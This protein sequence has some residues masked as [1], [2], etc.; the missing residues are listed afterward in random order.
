MER[1][2]LISLCKLLSRNPFGGVSKHKYPFPLISLK[3]FSTH[4]S[5]PQ[6][7]KKPHHFYH[8]ANL[9][10]PTYFSIFQDFRQY[11]VDADKEVDKINLKFVEAREDIESAMESKET[12]Y[13][14]EEAECAR[15]SVNEVLEM[16][17][18]LLK[19]LPDSQ[20]S[21][22]QRDMGLKIEQLKAELG[23]LNE[24]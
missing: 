1:R 12:V 21:S 10:S 6:Q 11:S 7:L 3:N 22:I 19:K 4:G 9:N 2:S 17:E 14:D 16:Y 24:D 8:P 20:R 13:F 5:V 15:A 18:G 23:Q